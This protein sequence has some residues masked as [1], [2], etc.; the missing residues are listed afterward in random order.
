MS[1]SAAGIVA[2]LRVVDGERQRRT[3]LPGLLAR[4]TALKAF[5]QRR[6]SHTYADLLQSPRYGAAARFFLEELYGPEDFSARDAQFARVAPTI[7]RLFPSDLAKT[8]T[9][10]SAL[11][12]LSETLD[13]AMG[14]QLAHA[15]IAP[16]DYIAAWQGVGREADRDRQIELTLAVAAQLD[17]ITRRP[18]LRNALRLMRG[19]AQAAG[20]AELQ[21]TL[22]SGFDT[23]KAMKGAEEFIAFIAKRE[24]ALAEALFA[25]GKRGAAGTAAMRT[26]LAALPPD[27]DDR[28]NR[29]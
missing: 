23:F 7:A 15:T 21:R 14:E 10:L 16:A 26:A 25:A 2:H 12:A 20:L 8:V 9:I 18:L 17:R 24:R 3:E 28:E 5:Q 4:V 29:L 13:S 11:H 19:P 1:A 27:T 22:E 6:F